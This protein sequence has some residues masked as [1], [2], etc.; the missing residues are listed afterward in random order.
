A[1]FMKLQECSETKALEKFSDL[2]TIK[3]YGRV[4]FI[5]EK[6]AQKD[7]ELA[8]KGM[9]E[10]KQMLAS[11]QYGLVILDEINIAEFFKLISIDEIINLI[12]TKPKHV[13][14]VLTGRKA[15]PR[16][17]EK[18]DLVTEMRE[19]KHYYAS[20]IRARKGIEN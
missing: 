17:I 20:G 7:I 11:G 12:D 18:A 19:I 2:I 4:R 1:Q 8:K 14:L 6:P 15:D 10:V 13:E 9:E 3:K 5:R 16:I